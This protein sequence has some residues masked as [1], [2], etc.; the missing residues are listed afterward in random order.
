M[1]KHSRAVGTANANDVRMESAVPTRETSLHPTE[2]RRGATSLNTV[3][4]RVGRDVVWVAIAAA[5][6]LVEALV[7]V[8]NLPVTKIF[9]R[10]DVPKISRLGH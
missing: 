4:A 10:R 5:F 2:S 8:T 9:K 6:C 3:G 1:N 7:F